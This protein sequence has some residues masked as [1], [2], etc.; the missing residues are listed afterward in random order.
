ME[1]G[2]RKAVLEIYE[3]EREMTCA[4]WISMIYRF[5]YPEKFWKIANY[6]FNSKKTFVPEK[7]VEKLEKIL[8]QDQDRELF[9]NNVLRKIV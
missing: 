4:E 5:S 2:G 1:H 8:E 3:K 9:I 7:N 6:Y